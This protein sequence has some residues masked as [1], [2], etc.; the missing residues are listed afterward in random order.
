MYSP[1]IWPALATN[2]AATILGDG[3]AIMNN[4]QIK[5]E[6]D[7]SV[8]P[9]T[10]QVIFAVTCV[11]TPAYP[12]IVDN[13]AAVQKNIDEAVLVYELTSK[14]FA[15][16]ELDLCHYWTPRETERFTGSDNVPAYCTS[17]ILSRHRPIQLKPS[18]PDSDH[19]EYSELRTLIA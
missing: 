19:W 8:R 11:D 7:A 1:R 18:E 12:P 9:Q 13:A 15:P 10:S 5:V 3:T 16:L 6:L 4:L 2:L 17:L 14:R